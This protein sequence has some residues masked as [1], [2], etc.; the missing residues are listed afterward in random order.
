MELM[1]DRHFSRDD[2]RGLGEG[3]TDS[4]PFTVTVGWLGKGRTGSADICCFLRQ[5]ALMLEPVAGS[6]TE[7]G[8]NC[9]KGMV[10]PTVMA[11]AFNDLLQHRLTPLLVWVG[12]GFVGAES[13]AYTTLCRLLQGKKPR[14]TPRPV[15]ACGCRMS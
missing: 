14:R 5:A 8:T 4:V 7:S 2:H 13:D 6:P 9:M 15:A 12:L 11:H 1:L 3:V 10:P